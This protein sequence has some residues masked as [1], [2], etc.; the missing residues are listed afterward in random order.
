VKFK[1]EGYECHVTLR[2]DPA[3]REVVERIAYQLQ[4]KTSV[5]LGDAVMGD[6]RLLYC[7]GHSADSRKMYERMDALV[8]ALRINGCQVLRQKIEHV[9]LDERFEQTTGPM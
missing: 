2:P 4:F 8:S 1:S 9:I 3:K 5:L 6:E 7:T